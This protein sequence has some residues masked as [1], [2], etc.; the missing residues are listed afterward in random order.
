MIILS[1]EDDVAHTIVPRL[2]AAGANRDRVHA[3]KA[4][5]E[6]DGV[7]RAFN[8]ALDLDRLD[9]DN[10]MGKVKLLVI[11]PVSAYLIPTKGEAS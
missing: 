7:E 9:K 11:D 4:V 3:V 10:D 6:D 1:A 2:I 8:L 5:K